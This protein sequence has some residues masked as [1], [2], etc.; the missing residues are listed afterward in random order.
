MAPSSIRRSKKW[1]KPKEMST[2]DITQVINEFKHTANLAF[3]AGYDDGVEI[4][5]AH[6]YLIHQ[7]CSPISNKKEQMN[8]R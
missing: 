8:I 1:P 7:F 6:G 4:H 5:M 2:K 3:K